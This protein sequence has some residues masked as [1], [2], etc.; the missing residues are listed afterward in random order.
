ME[1]APSRREYGS[2]PPLIVYGVW[3]VLEYAPTHSLS[4]RSLQVVGADQEY[5][6]MHV[7]SMRSM[8]VYVEDQEYTEY[9]P[10]VYEENAR[11]WSRSRVYGVWPH[12]V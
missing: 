1:H 3:G 6:P 9:V 11:I 7:L 10:M 5:H 12:G 2:C 8:Q 4:M